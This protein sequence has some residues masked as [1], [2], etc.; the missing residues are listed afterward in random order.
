MVAFVTIAK[1][2]ASFMSEHRGQRCFIKVINDAFIMFNNLGF[3][4]LP[5]IRTPS[6]QSHQ[7][8]SFVD[9]LVVK[10]VESFHH[11][12]VVI[13]E[14]FRVAIVVKTNGLLH[15][16]VRLYLVVVRTYLWLTLLAGS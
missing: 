5:H 13:I 1:I 10:V 8:N 4:P 11:T 6:N 12:T 15:A 9:V 2:S 7:W 16:T 3:L 14:A